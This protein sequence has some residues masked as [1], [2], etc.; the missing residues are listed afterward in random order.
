M[1]ELYQES[2]ESCSCKQPLVVLDPVGTSNFSGGE[3]TV[4]DYDYTCA[5]CGLPVR[6]PEPRQ[7]L[8]P[9]PF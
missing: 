2:R 4:Q 9:L 6:E 8:E 3:V 7:D 1:T 5:L